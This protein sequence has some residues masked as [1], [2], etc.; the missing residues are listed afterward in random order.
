MISNDRDTYAVLEQTLF[1]NPKRRA[2]ATGAKWPL[3]FGD[4]LRQR[5]GT[6]VKERGFFSGCKNRVFL[7]SLARVRPYP[8]GRPQDSFAGGRIIT[9][10]RY[11]Q[12]EP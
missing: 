5:P 11:L 4:I 12:T 2:H 7:R 1:V 8:E 10:N 3:A 9:K 6:D